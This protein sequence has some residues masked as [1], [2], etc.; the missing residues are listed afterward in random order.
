VA[1]L[2]GADADA[3][4]D[5]DV[6]AAG[7][8]EGVLAGV[9]GVANGGVA[10]TGVCAAGVATGLTKADDAGAA[11]DEGVTST[12]GDACGDAAAGRASSGDATAGLTAGGA[13]TE[14][15]AAAGAALG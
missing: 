2:V 11:G 3:D 14:G 15:A 9:A 13:D 8:V 4:V 5:V 7:L 10:M 1:A 6:D 12:P